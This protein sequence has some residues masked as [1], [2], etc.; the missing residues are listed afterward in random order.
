MELEESGMVFHL[1]EDR[2]CLLETTRFYQ[3]NSKYGIS[4]VEFITWYT[5]RNKECLTF[6]E[7][8][9][10]APSLLAEKE[11]KSLEAYLSAL[12][13]KYEHSLEMLYA[14]IHGRIAT[15]GFRKPL[16][17]AAVHPQDVLLLLIVKGYP[18]ESCKNLQDVLQKELRNLRHIWAARIIVLNEERARAYRLIV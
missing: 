8:K 4:A 13:R 6:V 15:L 9:S 16:A 10:S 2:T 14:A 11:S 17:Q 7:A 5:F 18:D 3:R 1:Q 12:A